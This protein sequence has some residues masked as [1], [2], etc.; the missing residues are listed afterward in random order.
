MPSKPPTPQGISALLRKAGFTKSVSSST[1]VR[2]FGDRSAGYV[3][4]RGREKGTVEVAYATGT[5]RTGP[6]IDARA[7]AKEDDYK[8]ALTAAG[9]DVQPSTS[10]YGGLTVTARED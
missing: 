7:K 1:R 2:G 8:R 5:F 3:V 4:S 9:W 6:D 10:I